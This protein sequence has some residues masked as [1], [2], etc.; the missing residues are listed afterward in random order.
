E[1]D[2]KKK[3]LVIGAGPARMEAAYV[4]KKRG[5]ELVLCEKSGD[6]GG[7]LRLA[8]VP[9]AK[10]E[11]CKVIKFMARRLKNQGIEDRM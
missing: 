6:F 2:E 7:L 1:A 4:A 10:Q 5:H 3:V 11:L 8:A 9:I